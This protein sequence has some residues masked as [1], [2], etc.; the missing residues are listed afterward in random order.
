VT[1]RAWDNRDQLVPWGRGP[2]RI[3]RRRRTRPGLQA[4]LW[5]MDGLLVD[6]EPVWTVAEEKL[7][8]RLG[9]TWSDEL[10]ARIVGTRLDV[11]VPT[12]L[13]W[14]GVEPTPQVVT[15]TSGWLLARM[16]E[17]YATEVRVLPGVSELLAAL[18]HDEIPMALV[19]SSYR[20]LVDAVLRHDVG[21]FAVT[22]AG[23]E[24]VHG[25]PAPEPYL[26]ACERLGVDPKQ[27]VVL[28]DSAAGVASGEA[29]GCA[30]AAVPS[31]VGVGFDPG[32]RRLVR[33]S[34]VGVGVQD[35]RALVA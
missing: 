8:E 10:K 35:L 22:V 11:S 5:D 31:V 13:R 3:L 32:V 30:V 15:E 18:T 20:V 26:L 34:L 12:I 23:D 21:P 14:Y 17:L 29:A 7:A 28:E 9:G 6:T 33:P 24:V 4:V 19:S 1:T 25:K 16:V 27:C 2:I